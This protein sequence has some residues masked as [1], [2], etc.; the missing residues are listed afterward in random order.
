MNGQPLHQEA[1][2]LEHDKWVDWFIRGSAAL[3]FLSAAAKLPALFSVKI[4]INKPDALVF[5]LSMKQLMVFSGVVEFFV[6]LFLLLRDLTVFGKLNLIFC[7]SF[8]FLCYRIGAVIARVHQPCPCWGN[9]SDWL[10]IISTATL[11]W[12]A[13]LLL[14]Y[15]LAGS[16]AGLLMQWLAARRRTNALAPALDGVV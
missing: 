11:D 1:T 2:V 8:S 9:L 13:K 12:I 15:F 6:A 7:L 4:S 10:P 16:G 5:F 14:V 3:L